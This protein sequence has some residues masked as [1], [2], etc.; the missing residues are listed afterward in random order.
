MEIDIGFGKLSAYAIATSFV[1][2]RADGCG[3]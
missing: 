3:C 1:R 2:I